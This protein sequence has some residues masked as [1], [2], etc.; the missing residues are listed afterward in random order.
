MS[1][2]SAAC[3]TGESGGAVVRPATTAD[4]EFLVRGNAEMALE[5]EHLS[6]DLDRLRDGVHAVFEQPERGVYYVAEVDGRRAGMMMIT[7]EWSDWRKGVFW[8]IQSVYVERTFRR[9]GVFKSLYRHVENL[10]RQKAE[11]CGLRLYVENNNSR[12]Q[13]IYE[14]LGMQKTVY[15]MFEVDFVLGRS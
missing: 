4:A 6:L 14:R 5:T 15:Q 3:G 1:G 9:Q 10:A 12:A 8:W 2:E 7:Y 13:A 11:V